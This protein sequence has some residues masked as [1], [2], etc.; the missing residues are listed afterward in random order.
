MSNPL[1][2]IAASSID[3]DTYTITVPQFA[4]LWAG[5]VYGFTGNDRQA[6]FKDC[7]GDLNK[8]MFVNNFCYASNDFITKTNTNM[9]YGVQMIL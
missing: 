4:D 6:L 3:C 9:V 5:L 7:I 2:A 8:D 1:A